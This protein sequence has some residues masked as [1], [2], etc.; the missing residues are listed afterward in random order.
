MGIH[1]PNPDYQSN[2]QK[3]KDVPI[4]SFAGWDPKI[5]EAVVEGFKQMRGCGGSN[6]RVTSNVYFKPN[7]EPPAPFYVDVAT[8]LIWDQ[9]DVLR[10][11]NTVKNI[12]HQDQA[13][14]R[15]DF[16]KKIRES[17]P[18]IILESTL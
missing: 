4:Y 6:Y 18:A 1:S 5:R 2:T 11:R 8:P 16:I 12:R 17:S 3:Q 13:E 7:S 15:R 9:F 14:I 10:R